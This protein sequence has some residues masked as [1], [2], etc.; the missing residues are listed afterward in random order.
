MHPSQQVWACPHWWLEGAS[1]EVGRHYGPH[2]KGGQQLPP[3]LSLPL[4]LLE[5]FMATSLQPISQTGR[6]PAPTP[7]WVVGSLNFLARF[8]ERLLHRV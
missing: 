2:R 7:A 3:P 1:P 4:Y 6:G 5:Q 8:R